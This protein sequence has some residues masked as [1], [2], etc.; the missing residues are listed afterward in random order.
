M[1]PRHVVNKPDK[2]MIEYLDFHYILLWIY[3]FKRIMNL[4]DITIFYTI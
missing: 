4:K 3:F 1:F 2:A